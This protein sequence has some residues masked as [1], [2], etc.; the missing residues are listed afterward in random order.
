MKIR[1]WG[2]R[3]SYPVPG[4]KTVKY[5][6]NTSCTEVD[7][8]NG[9]RIIL[10]AGTGLIQFGK[11]L[12]NLNQ[13]FVGTILLSHY[14][15]DH[16][17][18]IPFLNQIFDKNSKIKIRGYY[19]TEANPENVISKQI[20]KIYCPFEYK[21][22]LAKFEFEPVTEGKTEVEGIKV[23]TIFMNH[24][25]GSI[26]YKF[27]I[28]DKIFIYVTDNDISFPEI[29]Y[30]V[31]AYK[32]NDSKESGFIS[33]GV[34]KVLNFIQGADLLIHDS[35]YL[36]EE[37]NNKKGYGHSCF[38]DTVDLALKAG[39]KKLVLFHHDPDH[40]D[41]DVDLILQ[42]ALEKIKKSS[43]KMDCLAAREGL[44]IQ[45]N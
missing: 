19:G 21:D 42:K 14:H 43:Q 26:S 15:W 27:F 32:K 11:Y 10:D 44:E 17:Q 28:G 2:V 31:E 16:I 29:N 34:E 41:E 30:F 39:V 22:L 13:S 20:R 1:F 12:A 38:E 33:K 23:E 6:G 18:G 5:G 35:M 8:G 36:R 45:I 37:A 3:G 4:A 7:L 40:S 25:G 9:H 24:P